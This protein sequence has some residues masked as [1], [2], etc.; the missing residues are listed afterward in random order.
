MP[1]VLIPRGTVVQKVDIT[2]DDTVGNYRKATV[3]VPGY[4]TVYFRF[5][6]VRKT[7]EIKR[8]FKR[9]IFGG[10]GFRLT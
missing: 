10:G 7:C 6:A 4:G 2:V 5:L 1:T 3:Y 8:L 9:D